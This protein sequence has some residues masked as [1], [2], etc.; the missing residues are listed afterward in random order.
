MK[1]SIRNF[2]TSRYCFYRGE[3]YDKHI[4]SITEE[5]NDYL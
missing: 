3:L 1:S 4:R 2:I 5:L